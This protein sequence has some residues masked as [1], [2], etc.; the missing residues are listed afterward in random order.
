MMADLTRL[1]KQILEKKRDNPDFSPQQVADE[2][3]CSY[4]HAYDTLDK[5]DTAVLNET[6][7][8]ESSSS[9]SGSSS[10]S[11]NDSPSLLTVIFVW[12]IKLTLTVI[13]FGIKLTFA[14]LGFGLKIL[15]A[16]FG[17]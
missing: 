9:S 14:I 4:N 11:S 2:V 13:Q 16:I 1:Q 3:D 12:P 7:N 17:R 10:S 15:Q 8:S 6:D 5:Y